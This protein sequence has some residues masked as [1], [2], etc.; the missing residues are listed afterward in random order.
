MPGGP[1]R[2]AT[3]GDRAP[4][5]RSRWR[6]EFFRQN[7]RP[8]AAFALALAV[9]A[10]YRPCTSERRQAHTATL[11]GGRESRKPLRIKRKAGF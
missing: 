4:S 2:E 3:G 6:L 1:K 8:C 9:E 7:I 11:T 5:L 10:P